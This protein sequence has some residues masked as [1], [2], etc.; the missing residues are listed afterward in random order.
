MRNPRPERRS[1]D[2]R[3]LSVLFVLTPH[4]NLAEHTSEE[5]FTGLCHDVGTGGFSGWIARKPTATTHEVRF[6]DPQQR[7]LPMLNRAI[8][9]HVRAEDD[10]FIFG[11][12]FDQPLSHLDTKSSVGRTRA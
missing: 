9:R 8:I 12:E 10:G 3:N 4:R 6:V 1:S 11:A 7:M 2:R 5:S